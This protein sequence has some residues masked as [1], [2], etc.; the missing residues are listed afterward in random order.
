MCSSDLWRF[1][2]AILCLRL[3]VAMKRLFRIFI[4]LLSFSGTASP[5]WAG[6][7]GIGDATVKKD[8]FAVHLRGSYSEDNDNPAL[9]GRWRSRLM[10]D[11]GFTDDFALGLYIQGDNRSGDNQELDALMLESRFE[12]TEAEHHGFYSGFRLRYTYKDGDKKP[13]NAHI[14]LIFGLPVGQWDFRINQIFAYEIGEQ[15]AGGLGVDTRLQASY[16][17]NARHRAGIE[18]FSDFGYGSR[19]S[20]FTR[21]RHTIGPV[22]AGNISRN[23][24]YETGY[25]YGLSDAAADHTLKLFLI[26]NF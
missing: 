25:R 5:V 8:V 7:A 9:D 18:S 4:M 14:R 22:L 13:D 10:T 3:A 15:R 17:Y 24:S 12:L 23:L 1:R 21:Q 19:W 20:R 26:R 16:Y 2:V 11:Y 6:M